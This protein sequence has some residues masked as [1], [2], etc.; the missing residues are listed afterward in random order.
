MF[1][2]GL[3]SNSS[4]EFSEYS[5]STRERIIWPTKN[6]PSLI[7]V[8][9]GELNELT[10]HAFWGRELGVNFIKSQL[11][12]TKF[13]D[14]YR[15]KDSGRISQFIRL[16]VYEDVPDAP[17]SMGNFKL[18][19]YSCEVRNSFGQLALRELTDRISPF[20]PNP[21]VVHINC[22][23]SP[24]GYE[25]AKTISDRIFPNIDL[26]YEL[27]DRYL[28]SIIKQNNCFDFLFKKDILNTNSNLDELTFNLNKMRL[29]INSADKEGPE[30]LDT[31][32]RGNLVKIFNAIA[33]SI[34]QQIFEALKIKPNIDMILK[35]YIN[36][37]KQC[38]GLNL[39][40][41][42]SRM[43]LLGCIPIPE[44][45]IPNLNAHD[46]KITDFFHAFLDIKMGDML[47]FFSEISY[48]ELRKKLGE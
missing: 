30:P 19:G 34:Y 36:K 21:S 42:K 2:T 25:L 14:I 29:A 7:P 9:A 27:T 8:L 22:A 24:R 15:E 37:M 16:D 23:F 13:L 45:I 33:D 41:V 44:A 39:Q 3:R 35:F 43:A 47:L 12:Q 20:N 4:I 48:E 40:F 38:T 32:S 28:K 46:E 5:R 1:L 18:P 6:F 11:E 26:F 31:K 17:V 10:K